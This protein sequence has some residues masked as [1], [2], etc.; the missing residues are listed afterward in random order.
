MNNQ[1]DN[2]DLPEGAE[3]DPEGVWV[4]FLS[5]PSGPAKRPAL[6]L[7]RD[8]VIVEEVGYLH[9]PN[10]VRLIP[11]AAEVIARANAVD[12]PVVIVTNQGG[13]GRGVFNW[14]DFSATQERILYDLSRD[15][16]SVDAVMASPHHPEA[17]APYH[18]PNH[19]ARK[20]NPGMLLRAADTLMIDLVA[21]WIIG[22]HATDAEAGLNAGLAGS[23]HVLTGH[24][25]HDG[26]REQ[27]LAISTEDFQVHDVNAIADALM[28]IPFLKT[29]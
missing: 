24:G 14:S 1:S 11:G 8:G 9:R 13:I 18:H 29:R 5:R 19:P 4:Q 27:A 7:D 28:L 15:G 17:Q 20:P 10:E 3:I 22:D 12:S 16:A 6:F 23:I 26:E 2:L 21:S 25:A